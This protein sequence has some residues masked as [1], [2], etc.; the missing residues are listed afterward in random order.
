MLQLILILLIICSILVILYQTSTKSNNIIQEEFTTISDGEDKMIQLASKYT[1]PHTSP[2]VGM[3]PTIENPIF[4]Q[5]S[6]I[7]SK[8]S[9]RFIW[10]KPLIGSDFIK[11]KFRITINFTY[12]V[13]NVPSATQTTFDVI[14]SPT[15]KY[16]SE[17]IRIPPEKIND[18]MQ[19][20]PMVQSVSI[21][22]L[23]YDSVSD[24]KPIAVEKVVLIKTT[25]ASVPKRCVTAGNTP[26][27]CCLLYTSPSPRD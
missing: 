7:L 8:I 21:E 16:V 18:L 4:R 13:E 27:N 10:N 3:I 12:K 15:D 20:D 23:N 5:S 19:H 22:R 24:R 2:N 9:V 14:L 26:R 17:W 1:L 25:D 6:P 11:A